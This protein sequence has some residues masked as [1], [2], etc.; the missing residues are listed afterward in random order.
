M[1]SFIPEEDKPVFEKFLQDSNLIKTAQS[2]T[3]Q[4]L[5]SSPPPVRIPP[6]P[7]AAPPPPPPMPSLTT[8]SPQGQSPQK[9]RKGRQH[10]NNEVDMFLHD[11]EANMSSAIDSTDF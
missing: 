1:G 11:F 4:P 3:P 8:S 7:T 6:P 2:G 5:H 9:Q 10:Q